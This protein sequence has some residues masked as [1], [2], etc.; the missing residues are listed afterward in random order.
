MSL[1]ASLFGSL[2]QLRTQTEGIM[3]T[4]VG[5]REEKRRRD[6]DE[7]G[8]EERRGRKKKCRNDLSNGSGEASARSRA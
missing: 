6:K 8:D 3:R 1:D 2:W 5:A 4:N 7:K